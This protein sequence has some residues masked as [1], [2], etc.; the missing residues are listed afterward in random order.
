[1][2]VEG[3]LPSF[4]HYRSG[5]LHEVAAGQCGQKIDHV[6]IP[7]NPP[8]FSSSAKTAADEFAFA[9]PDLRW[10]LL[11]SLAVKRSRR[12]LADDSFWF[13]LGVFQALLIVGFG[14]EPA[15]TPGGAPT[16]Y[17]IAKISWGAR[18][19]LDTTA[20][21]SLNRTNLC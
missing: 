17:W 14:S 21:S 19:P 6:R 16:P 20:P 3:T 15:A 13:S 9:A 4:Q 18:T 10:R 12:L 1:M 7:P 2:A 11:K 5:V 8:G